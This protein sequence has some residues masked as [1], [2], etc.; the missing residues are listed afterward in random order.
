LRERVE[1]VGG[2]VTGAPAPDGGW[3]LRAD[4]PAPEPA[5]TGRLDFA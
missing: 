3:L 2:T 4:L 1:A 5:L